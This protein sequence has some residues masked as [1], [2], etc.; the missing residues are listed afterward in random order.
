MSNVNLEDLDAEELEAMAELA[1][2]AVD[3][4]GV[5]TD[6]WHPDY[7]WIMRDGEVTE[8]GKLLAI[9]MHKRGLL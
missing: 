3:N 6:L 2:L 9:D 4:F 7:G 1:K 5:P 8:E